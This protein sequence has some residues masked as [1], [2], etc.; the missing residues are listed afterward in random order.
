MN[1][2]T[3]REAAA[4]MA[5]V[6]QRD[7]EAPRFLRQVEICKRLG[8][9]VTTWRRWRVNR[10]APD[11]VPNVPGVPRWRERDI[12]DFERG[13]HTRGRVFFSAARRRAS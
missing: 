9:G 5:V 2:K 3:P 8:V 12:A 13:L 6:P 10:Q 11:P 1:R 4:A 7:P